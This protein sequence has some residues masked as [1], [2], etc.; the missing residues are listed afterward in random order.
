MDSK[1]RLT[2]FT[3]LDH[4]E[5]TIENEQPTITLL[6]S[7]T[8]EEFVLETVNYQS[9]H[10]YDAFKTRAMYKIANTPQVILA[11]RPADKDRMELLVER[12]SLPLEHLLLKSRCEGTFISIV[13][14]A[15]RTLA[16]LV[17]KYG[18]FRVTHKMIRCSR[19]GNLLVWFH[20]NTTSIYREMPITHSNPSED[21]R[22]LILEIVGIFEEYVHKK[23]LSMLKEKAIK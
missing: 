5:W 6:H 20:E 17:K 23:V 14:T 13:K 21:T 12:G 16:I 22:S 3:G 9:R 11:D 19:S 7:Y 4:R 18:F 1:L 15:L 10:C 2:N 8:G